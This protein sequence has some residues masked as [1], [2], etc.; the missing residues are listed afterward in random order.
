M[1]LSEVSALLK[2]PI[3]R[4][5]SLQFETGIEFL[6]G[7]LSH[8]QSLQ[9]MKGSQDFWSW[10]RMT[11]SNRD[12]RFVDSGLKTWEEYQS[13]HEQNGLIEHPPRFI[14]EEAIKEVAK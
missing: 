3:E 13:W 9:A 7:N 4:L 8:S 5:T 11:W 10:W 12:R 2:F 6:E 1:K 14:L